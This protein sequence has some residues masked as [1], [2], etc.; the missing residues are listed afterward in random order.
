MTPL[1]GRLVS[2]AVILCMTCRAGVDN[3]DSRG[4][5]GRLKGSVGN[6]SKIVDLEAETAGGPLGNGAG[7]P[8]IS[9]EVWLL[10]SISDANVG[11]RTILSNAWYF[12]ASSNGE[13][14]ESY[15]T[16]GL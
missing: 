8:V 4:T 15:H 1:I 13:M 7:G 14:R 6:I 16:L 3:L 5:D 9:R 12:R 10:T 2:L 11:Q